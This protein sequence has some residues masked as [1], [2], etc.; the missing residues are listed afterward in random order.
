MAQTDDR[1]SGGRAVAL[2]A[3]FFAFLK[4]S[5]LAFGGGLVWARRTVCDERHWLDDEEFADIVS[6]CQFLPGP[7][8]VGIAV[9]V[10]AKLRGGRG[11]LAALGGFTLVPWT[12]GFALGAL[13]LRHAGL[14]LLQHILAG[15]SAAAAGLL[16]AT[17]FRLLRPYRTRPTALLF[18]ALAFAGM[19]FA[20]L[21]LAVVLL[22]LAPLSIAAAGLERARPA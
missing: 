12:V 21:P 19:I 10:G 8:I 15:V 7:N 13:Y 4:V 20:K 11:A 2:A 18:A 14:P 5:M 16:I 17:G 9:C 1:S 3:L 22:A 6:L